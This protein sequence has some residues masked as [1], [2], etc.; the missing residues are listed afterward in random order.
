MKA[1][2]PMAATPVTRSPPAARLVAAG[3][4]R[5]KHIV[6]VLPIESAERPIRMSGYIWFQLL[7]WDY[8]LVIEATLASRKFSHRII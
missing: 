7:A 6:V 4:T 1:P 5:M 2:I 3:R 8:Y